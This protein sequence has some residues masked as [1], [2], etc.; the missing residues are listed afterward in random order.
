MIVTLDGPAGAGKSTTA[1]ALAARLGWC[2]LDTG[3]MYRTVALVALE[4]G[5]SLEDEERLAAV[6]ESLAIQF[7]QGRVLVGER[8]VSEAIRTE[9]VTKA[10]R[11]VADAP[12]VREAMKHLQRR[13]AEGLDIVT[14]GRDQGSE[15]FPRAELKVFLTASPEERARRRHR[16]ELAR[17]GTASLAAVLEAQARRDDGDR[18]RPVGAMRPADDAVVFETDGLSP[19]EVLARLVDLV[20]ARR[21]QGA[22]R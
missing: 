5:L 16:E 12:A 13:L 15:V 3:A 17:G 11:P 6:A 7:C 21:P 19:E 22:G 14:E 9:Q 4:Q 18:N 2:Y 20:I 8:D 1:R 10:T